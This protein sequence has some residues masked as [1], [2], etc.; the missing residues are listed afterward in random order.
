M[1]VQAH[2]RDHFQWQRINSRLGDTLRIDLSSINSF[3]LAVRALLDI[4]DGNPS[5]DPLNSLHDLI[6]TSKTAVNLQ[7]IVISAHHSRFFLI[8]FIARFCTHLQSLDG[9]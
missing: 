3:R 2:K 5:V 1:R 7:T 6:F 4:L 8:F 9:Y